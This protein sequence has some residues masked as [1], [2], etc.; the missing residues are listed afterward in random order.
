MTVVVTLRR[1]VVEVM[2]LVAATNVLRRVSK[3]L[4]R[5]VSILLV[6]VVVSYVGVSLEI[7]IRLLLIITAIVFPS[8][9]A[10]LA[11]LRVCRV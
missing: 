8:S 9:M 4:A 5:F 3:V 7:Q 11:S 6:L 2:A 1:Q 10:V